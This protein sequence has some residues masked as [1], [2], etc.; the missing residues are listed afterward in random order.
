MPNKPRKSEKQAFK[1]QQSRFLKIQEA[2]FI[3]W[4]ISPL[5]ICYNGFVQAKDTI[6]YWIESAEEDYRTA[7]SL[8]SVNRFAHCLFF[9]HLMNEKI[10]KA[11]VVKATNDYAP[12]DHNLSLLATKTGMEFSSEQL[13]LLDEINAFNIKSRYD[14]Y[15]FKFYKKATKEYAEKYFNESTKLYLWLKEQ[16]T[17]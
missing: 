15:K 4:L 10:L 12:F 6:A 2:A 5:Q 3:F 16:I 1:T 7:Q 11:L 9:C 14:D 17:K 8:L 13:D